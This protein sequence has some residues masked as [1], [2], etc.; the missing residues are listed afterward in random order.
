MIVL[1]K[2]SDGKRPCIHFITNEV[3]VN[4]VAQ[5]A[6]ISNTSP[7]MVCDYRVLR[8][9]YK[10]AKV[11]V[12]NTGTMNKYKYRLMN[13]AFR[14]AKK[15]GLPI[16]LDPVG[17]GTINRRCKFAMKLLASKQV[18]LL[19][20]NTSEALALLGYDLRGVGVD[21]L[22]LEEK[23]SEGLAIEL[24]NRYKTM[25]VITGKVDIVADGERVY[26]VYGGDKR[27]RYI[28]GTGCMLNAFLAPLLI[29]NDYGGES[30]YNRL[31]KYKKVA[32]EVGKA[33]DTDGLM[34]FKRRFLDGLYNCV[35]K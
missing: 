4:D 8:A 18:T 5:M 15:A 1:G 25:V 11:L 28:V 33:D 35:D 17:A 26:K 10:T 3:T 9:L 7:I 32:E 23:K 2:L 27:L 16:L 34:G 29:R 14:E 21:G 30:V 12:V 20:C 19:K 22:V 24:A 13:K 6:I 31:V